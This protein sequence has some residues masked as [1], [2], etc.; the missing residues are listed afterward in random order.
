MKGLQIGSTVRLNHNL[1]NWNNYEVAVPKDTLG[2]VI[3]LEPGSVLV[4]FECL[5]NTT[6]LLHRDEVEEVG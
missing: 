3:S 2:K 4:E 6:F 5:P 1:I